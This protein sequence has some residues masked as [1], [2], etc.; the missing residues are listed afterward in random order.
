MTRWVGHAA[1]ARKKINAY[2][3][4]LRKSEVKRLLG[5]PRIR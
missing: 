4:L 2:K 1:P 3:I 5:R